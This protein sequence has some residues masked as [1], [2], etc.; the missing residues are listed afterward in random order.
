[1]PMAKIVNATATIG[2]RRGHDLRERWESRFILDSG[3]DG[4]CIVGEELAHVYDASNDVRR[5]IRDDAGT[6][7]P[8]VGL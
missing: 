7:C 4:E 2:N 1:M 8:G 6:L 3:Q 5:S